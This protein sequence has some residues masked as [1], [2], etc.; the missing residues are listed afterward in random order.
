MAQDDGISVNG[1]DYSWGSITF[2][3]NG[4]IFSGFTKISYGDKRTRTKGYSAGRHHAPTHR[5]NGKYE[6]DPSKVTG[7]KDELQALRAWLALQSP[8]GV[9]YGNVEFQGVIQFEER[10]KLHQIDLVDLVW[11]EDSAAHEESPD[12]L[13][14]EVSFDPMRI[15]R[16]GL[17]LFDASEGAPQKAAA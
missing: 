7:Y 10:D 6:V 3:C 5:S 9:S 2:K 12:L 1:V 4:A 14:E 13:M 8:D 11:F 16:D 17:C 15:L